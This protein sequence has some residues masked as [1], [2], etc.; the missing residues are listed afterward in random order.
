M[1]I[2]KFQV[3]GL[4][5]LYN[6]TL[7]F[8]NEHTQSSNEGA[9]VVMIFGRNG[10]GKTTLLRMIDGLMT[11]NF[12]VFRNT[13]FEYAC[14]T[15]SNGYNIS[16][17]QIAAKEG[18][19]YLSVNYRNLETKL[20]PK[21]KGAI[22]PEEQENE[23]TFV[24]QYNKD[25]DKFS[26]EFIDTERL[27]RKNLKD[28]ILAE[29]KQLGKIF[30]NQ[31]IDTNRYLVDKVKGFIRDSQINFSN[32]FLRTEPELF[33]KILNNLENLKEITSSDLLL[34]IDNLL[35]SEIDYKIDDLGLTKEKWDKEKL[36][37]TITKSSSNQNKLTIIA[38][39]IEVLESRN[40]ERMSLAERLIKFES[41]LNEFLFDK[42]ITINNEGFLIN[43][44]NQTNELLNESQLSTGEYHLL[45]LTTL[46]LCTK[47]KGTVIAIDEPEM[48]MHIGWQR[49]LVDTLVKIS[50]KASPQMIFA[51]HSPDIAVNYSNSLITEDYVERVN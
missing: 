40:M 43:S 9:S 6:H 25:L 5:D 26:F 8:T 33:E 35:K 39:Y 14:L 11:L 37:E 47:V 7:D 4:F 51:T 34:R 42:T 30:K 16:V 3:T 41:L 28:E 48:S 13:K 29:A 24:K 32:Y 22:S 21:E 17:K 44:K 10:V 20:H 38:S 2:D 49:K 36:K 46:A 45:Y 18:L 27:I 23:M 19:D 50:S 15:F 12:D 1:K 31:R